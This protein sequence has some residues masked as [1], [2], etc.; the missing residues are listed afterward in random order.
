MIRYIYTDCHRR[1]IGMTGNRILLLLLCV[2][3]DGVNEERD[4]DDGRTVSVP[5]PIRVDEDED[6][7]EE[8][9]RRDGGDEEWMDDETD[10]GRVRCDDVVVVENGDGDV[11]RS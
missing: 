10:G 8:R 11:I 5:V 4:D 9:E 3:G 7:D 6:E 2:I 1:L